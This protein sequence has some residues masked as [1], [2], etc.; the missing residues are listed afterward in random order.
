MTL[1]AQ[2]ARDG[3][4]TFPSD[5]RLLR[6]L[7]H[8]APA[9]LASSKDA[10][11]RA[12]WLDC[13][14][15]WFIGV[16]ALKNDASGD[17]NASGPLTCD[18]MDFIADLG[19]TRPLHKGQVSV[20]W[21]GYPRPRKGETEAALG[22]RRNRDAA[23]LDG[24][25]PDPETRARRVEEPHAWVLGIPMNVAAVGA[26]PLVIWRGSHHIMQ[27]ALAPLLLAHTPEDMDK[28]DV[29]EAYQAARREVFETC[30][31]VEIT[32]QPGESYVMHRHM[33]HGVAPW[34]EGTD[35]GPDG[36]AIVYFRP[37]C[38]GGVAEWISA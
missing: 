5:A 17:V 3:L 30:E 22:Y 7:E 8:A 32:A 16:D 11:E 10:D 37:E 18:A 34:R 29:T 25:R 6:W 33:L 1:Q 28:V 21:P 20:V 4:V 24:L 38:A 13:E 23:H 2:F 36:R 12:A 35:S 9:G 19:Q 15:T 26:S 14:G 27:R 31:R